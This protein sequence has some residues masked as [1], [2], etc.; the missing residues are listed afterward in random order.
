MRHGNY[1]GKLSSLSPRHRWT[2]TTGA[3]AAGAAAAL[4]HFAPP[5]LRHASP[6][7]SSLIANRLALNNAR[8]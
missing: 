5:R 6:L 2:R 8:S 7:R 1:V 3:L 4:A